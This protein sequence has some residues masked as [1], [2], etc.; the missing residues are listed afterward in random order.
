MKIAVATDDYITVTG[1]VGRCNGFIIFDVEDGEIKNVEQRENNFTHHKL[2]NDYNN[3]HG[4]S[5][6]NLV[7]ALSDCTHLICTSAG[8]RLRDDITGAKKELIFTNEKLA[9][10]AVIKLLNGTLEINEEGACHSH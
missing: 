8:W 6:A 3:S 2:S 10:E 1:H 9:E 4:H 7:H 5:H